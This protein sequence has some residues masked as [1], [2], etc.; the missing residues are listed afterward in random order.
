[1]SVGK[2]LREIAASLPVVV[3]LGQPL[4][5]AALID[6]ADT[7]ERETALLR[8]QVAAISAENAALHDVMNTPV[9]EPFAEAVVSEAQHQRL[10]HGDEHDASKSPYDWFW[11]L[12]YL[13]GKAARAHAEGDHAAAL[14]HTVTSA[15]LLAHWHRQLIFARSAAAQQPET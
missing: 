13:S 8:D 14:H 11:T 5:V 6:A 1:V 15:A 3:T 10:R 4:L 7:Y 9:V 2:D 12:G